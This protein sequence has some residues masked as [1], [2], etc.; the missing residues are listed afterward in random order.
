MLTE[1]QKQTPVVLSNEE[2]GLKARESPCGKKPALRNA[3]DRCF[4]SQEG[5]LSDLHMSYA[6]K[7]LAAIHQWSAANCIS[8][9][10]D[11]N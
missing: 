5:E 8:D 10:D 9:K 7:F 2:K 11:N 4:V 3:N 1:Q 6:Q